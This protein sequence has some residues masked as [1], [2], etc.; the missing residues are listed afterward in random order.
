MK[1]GFK[2]IASI[3]LVCCMVL[4]LLPRAA[5][6]ETSPASVFTNGD[7]SMENP[8]EVSTAE[9]LEA[10]RNDLSA[11]YVQTC[12]IDLS[13]ID[14][15]PIGSEDAPFAGSYDGDGH[16]VQNLS[17]TSV[18]SVNSIGLWGCAS[19]KSTIANVKLVNCNIRL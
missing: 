13:G 6:A 11:Y 16:E 3:L 12:D 4:G 18:Y 19:H 2:R 7:G 9:Q 15:E 8:Y 14:W 10:V 17:L 1:R 5:A